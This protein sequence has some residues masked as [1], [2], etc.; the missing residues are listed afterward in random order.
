MKIL[1]LIFGIAL[2][3][4]SCTS[5]TEK[6]LTVSENDTSKY[7]TKTKSEIIEANTDSTL[8]F[9]QQN[10]GERQLFTGGLKT[11]NGKTK[12]NGI[13][14]KKI[15]DNQIEYSYSQLINWKKE[16]DKDGIAELTNI[17]DSILTVKNLKE[18]AYKFIDAKNDIVIYVTKNDNVNQT[19]AKVFNKNGQQI[20]ALMY[21]K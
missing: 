4:C 3:G 6:K 15:A 18:P 10:L 21:N 13:Y 11:D 16:F 14:V 7:V 8:T 1:I 20:S 9:N 19:R 17:T 12:T 2:F 5:K